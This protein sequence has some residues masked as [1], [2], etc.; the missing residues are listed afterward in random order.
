MIKKVF[1]STPE[2]DVILDLLSGLIC[3]VKSHFQVVQFIT[4]CRQFKLIEEG[5][6]T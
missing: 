5:L 2:F 3:R 6:D 4:G 1:V